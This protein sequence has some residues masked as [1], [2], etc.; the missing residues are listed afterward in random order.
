M[1]ATAQLKGEPKTVVTTGQIFPDG[2]ILELVCALN[3]S[4]RLD[5]LFWNGIKAT[6]SSRVAHDGC[7]YEPADVPPSLYH[8]T[9]FPVRYDPY[10]SVRHLL[11]QT[12]QLFTQYL[13]FADRE[14]R[15]LAVFAMST[16]IAD[17]L[18]TAP[19]LVISGPDQRSGIGLL[20][21][22]HCLCRRPVLLAEVTPV[23]LRALPIQFSLTL[24]INQQGLRPAM[25]RFL[26]VAQHR[27]MHV[28][29]NRGTLIDLYGPKAIFCGGD[30][31]ESLSESAIQISTA[32][33]SGRWIAID[34]QLQ[35]RI[36]DEFQPQLLSYRL[37]N[38]S[39]L[40]TSGIEVEKLSAATE[41][42]AFIIAASLS[43]DP[44]LAR[45]TVR[46]LQ[47]QADD[48]RAQQLLDVDRV[49]VEVLWGLIHK[50]ATNAVL[51]NDLA[52]YVNVLLQS[53]GVQLSYSAVEIGW[54]LR[55]AGIPRHAIAAGR[56]VVLDVV[57]RRRIH[58][59]ACYYDF[60]SAQS[61]PDCREM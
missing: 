10:N 40:S 21:L 12:E 38:V 45:E 37:Q 52:K 46:L 28:L 59:L 7:F 34:E 43:E 41:Q 13:H 8:A 6:V 55:A 39:K 61:V 42:L 16:W 29:G 3:W 57:N 24:L 1:K 23:G 19:T 11:N 36:A 56:E 18:P 25:L 17:R 48:I 54:K 20:K 14:A 26:N 44:E 60:S 53:R 33:A 5:L 2:T 9:R 51:V 22:L 58:N 4:R 27:G 32:Q 47:A 49:L 30:V 35:K 50:E 31:I 15:L